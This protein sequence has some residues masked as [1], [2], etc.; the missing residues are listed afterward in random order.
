MLAGVFSAVVAKALP[1]RSGATS[2][3]AQSPSVDAPAATTPA[4]PTDGGGNPGSS[5]SDPSQFPDTLAPPP[6][7]PAR[8][9][10]GSRSAVVSG[11][12]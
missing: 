3:A 10:S 5:V 9:S 4:N 2:G 11:G 8:S 6:Q 7:L 1:G 12:S